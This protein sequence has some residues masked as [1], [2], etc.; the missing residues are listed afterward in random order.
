MSTVTHPSNAA[1][2]AS[3]TIAQLGG[4]SRR[5]R[6]GRESA[7]PASVAVAVDAAAAAADGGGGIALREN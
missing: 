1:M 5:T 3:R 7:R 4:T 6:T 2:A